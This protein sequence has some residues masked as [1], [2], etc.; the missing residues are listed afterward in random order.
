MDKKNGITS[1]PPP[2]LPEPKAAD[3]PGKTAAGAD[4]AKIHAALSLGD[5]Y[6]RERQFDEAI[7]AYQ[8]GLREDPSNAELRARIDQ[9]RK[10]KPSTLTSGLPMGSDFSSAPPPAQHS[11]GQGKSQTPGRGKFLANAL[12]VTSFILAAWGWIYPH[13]YFLVITPLALLPWLAVI[14]VW[15][16]K[17]EF[18]SVSLLADDR[19]GLLGVLLMVPALVLAMDALDIGIV[20]EGHR[21]LFLAIGI[22]LAVFLANVVVEPSILSQP[23]HL[24]LMLIFALP[25]GYG[26]GIAANA[27]FDRS[28]ATV[29]SAQIMGKDTH[30][31]SRS[32]SYYLELS[33]WGPYPGGDTV[34]ASWLFYTSVKVGD[35]VCLPLRPGALG[36]AWF[37]VERCH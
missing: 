29:Y 6:C 3:E 11:T 25:Y 4:A 7:N 35:P 9:L 2:F 31:G 28:P 18:T 37:T 5:F 26:A 16:S 33:P 22:G 21:V 32:T 34:N 36:V 24:F 15:K 17:G 30:R 20:Y 1:R 13:P 23:R 19:R 27:L 10:G 8:D 12:G 14:V